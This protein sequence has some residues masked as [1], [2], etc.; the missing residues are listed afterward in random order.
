VVVPPELN[1]V[2]PEVLAG[3]VPPQ[4]SHVVLSADLEVASQHTRRVLDRHVRGFVGRERLPA[5]ADGRLE[6][7]R[8]VLLLR[9]ASSDAEHQQGEH[10]PNLHVFTLDFL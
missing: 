2:E 1:L 4:V 10:H 3:F 7:K 8:V 5:L 9:L 6:L